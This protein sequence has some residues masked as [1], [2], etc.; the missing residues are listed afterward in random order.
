MISLNSI[1]YDGK[2]IILHCGKTTRC[3]NF[4]KQL[5]DLEKLK[6]SNPVTLMKLLL[7]DG[8]ITSPYYIV[9]DSKI[10]F[11]VSFKPIIQK[12]SI[13][14]KSKV[15]LYVVEK[16]LGVNVGEVYDRS[17]LGRVKKLIYKYLSDIGYFSPKIDY[18]VF[19]RNNNVEISFIVKAGHPSL[20]KTISVD[21]K[22][23]WVK[24]YYVKRMEE[25]VN[26]PFNFN[27]VKKKT[28]DITLGLKEYGYYL[29]NYDLNY[30]NQGKDI[31][32][33]LKVTNDKQY[34]F[35][36]FD[37]NNLNKRTLTELVL[38]TFEKFKGSA[39]ESKFKEELVEYYYN[40]G[41]Q[42][43][44][45]IITTSRYK[46]TFNVDTV[47]TKI[48]VKPDKRTKVRGVFFKGNFYFSEKRLKKEYIDGAFDLAS[49]NIFD[50]I[51]YSQFKNDL[52]KKYIKNGFVQIDIGK[53]NFIFSKDKEYV[54]IVFNIKE[55]V[56]TFV[57]NINITGLPKDVKEI[58][59]QKITNKV[60]S[61]FD[62]LMFE[63]DL[64]ILLE[65][66]KELGYFNAKIV[67]VRDD[68]IVEYSPDYSL[69]NINIDFE[70]G[71][72]IVLKSLYYVGNEKTKVRILDS[73]VKLNPK[74]VITPNKLKA[75]KGR[76]NALGLFQN[77][78]VRPLI[79]ESNSSDTDLLISV[80]EKK[81][82][83]FE[84]APGFR[85]DLG[86]KISF[87]A[88]SLNVGGR[89]HTLSFQAQ[90]NRRISTT[91]LDSQ[92]SQEDKEFIESNIKVNYLARDMFPS[93]D[94]NVSVSAQERRF[95]SFDANI[96]RFSNTVSTNIFNKL[97][98]SLRYQLERVKQF[99]ATDPLDEG[100]FNIGAITTSF[101][102]DNKNK[103][104]NATKG[105]FHNLSVEFAHPN[106]RSDEDVEYYKVV[107]RN[108]FYIDL[109]RWV[110]ALYLS[111][112]YQ[113][114][115]AGEGNSIPDIKAFRLTGSDTVRGFDF[116]EINRLKNGDLL[117]DTEFAQQAYLINLKI[118]PRY[119]INDN[120]VLG[121]FYDAGR[122]FL[123]NPDPLDL[124]SSVGLSFKYLTPVG[125]LD[126]DYGFKTLRKKKPGG[127]LE[128][129]GRLHISIGFF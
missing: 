73:E 100:Q 47:Q 115:L 31:V 33:N 46:N 108:N 55:G 25:L 72:K 128:T 29:I 109:D 113:K 10:N 87:K 112:G 27:I 44:Q 110:M 96:L 114:N 77:I 93:V 99:D 84:L 3:E 16:S 107:N 15:D 43:P 98:T 1:A 67:N 12:I 35:N 92:R 32:L 119:Y 59:L 28:D 76:L 101:V 80:E 52:K 5:V 17:K 123:E 58:L 38:K 126:F 129:P 60:E 50:P 26:K 41:F 83:V 116:D 64:Q 20:L 127:T 122:V 36:F 88:D 4:K 14:T 18:E 91:A 2:R 34:V 6:G 69:V 39:D 21:S 78:Q 49:R 120:M 81:Y 53:T 71:K 22:Y 95:Y 125:S 68:N 97:N 104:V 9:E 30:K 121:I 102:F 11:Y 105:S 82:K 117:S 13:S 85:T 89:N 118:E 103:R 106:F 24:D 63:K 8:K 94:N 111:L 45:I 7:R 86:F 54:D 75:I 19:N 66:V 65:E 74:D 70:V 124:R 23:G 42:K 79:D 37:T 56:R 61:S 57:E 51:Y 62:P 48:R 90:A 40:K